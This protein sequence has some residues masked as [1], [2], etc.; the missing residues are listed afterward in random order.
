MISVMLPVFLPI[1]LPVMIP[2][3]LPMMI[4][5]V[6]PVMLPMM[7]PVILPVILPIVL[8]MVLL[9]SISGAALPRALGAGTTEPAPAPWLA[10]SLHPAAAPP[11][12]RRSGVPGA[13]AHGVLAGIGAT[14]RPSPGGGNGAL[15]SALRRGRPRR[16]REEGAGARLLQGFAIVCGICRENGEDVSVPAHP[17]PDA[18]RWPLLLSVWLRDPGTR[19]PGSGEVCTPGRG[20]RILWQQVLVGSRQEAHP[21]Y[22]WSPSGLLWQVMTPLEGPEVSQ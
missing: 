19:G 8:P 6:L 11:R 17:A 1:V 15:S 18:R 5:I 12:D 2:V 22:S 3:V 4:P 7:L 9:I 21:G 20:P 13:Q 14:P 16:P 10:A